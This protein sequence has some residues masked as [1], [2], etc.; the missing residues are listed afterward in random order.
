MKQL[1]RDRYLGQSRYS[2]WT[3]TKNAIG[4]YQ[5]RGGRNVFEIAQGRGNKMKGEQS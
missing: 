4:I 1:A 3:N 5:Q 2:E